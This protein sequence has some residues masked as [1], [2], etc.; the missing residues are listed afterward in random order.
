MIV[1][2]VKNEVLPWIGVFAAIAVFAGPWIAFSEH[3]AWGWALLGV[4]AD[5]IGVLIVALI[6]AVKVSDSRKR[7][8]AARENL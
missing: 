6:I 8:S 5:L 1:R 2:E 3:H 4:L 7:Q